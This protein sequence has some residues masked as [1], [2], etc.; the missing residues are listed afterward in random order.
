MYVKYTELRTRLPRAPAAFIRVLSS[1]S[2]RHVTRGPTA[3]RSAEY[4]ATLSERGGG[5]VVGRRE[6]RRERERFGGRMRGR[7]RRGGELGEGRKKNARRAG[8]GGDW[9]SK[10]E[11]RRCKKRRQEK[12]RERRQEEQR[13]KTGGAKRGDR[14]SRGRE[15][16]RSKERRQEVQRERRKGLQREKTGGAEREDRRTRRPLCIDCGCC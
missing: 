10:R 16:R 11:D 3:S 2:D 6:G 12:Q 14:R 5:G 4:S 13:E 1:G 8:A 9:R 7:Q 15:D